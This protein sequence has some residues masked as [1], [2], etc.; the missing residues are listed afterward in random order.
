MI[1]F[2]NVTLVAIL[3]VLCCGRLVRADEYHIPGAAPSA[4]T[5]RQKANQRS[6]STTPAPTPPLPEASDAPGGGKMVIL[7]ERFDRHTEGHRPM[8]ANQPINSQRLKIEGGK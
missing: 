5:P 3:L 8:E 1:K 4:S 6:D 7:D 2:R